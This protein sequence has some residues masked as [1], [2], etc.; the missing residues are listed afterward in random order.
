MKWREGKEKR[1]QGKRPDRCKDSINRTATK[2][3][4]VEDIAGRVLD[5]Q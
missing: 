1:R 5:S 2:R 3:M 4:T